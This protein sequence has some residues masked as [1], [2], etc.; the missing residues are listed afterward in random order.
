MPFLG[1]IV[2]HTFL[3][4][5][6]H[7]RIFQGLREREREREREI[8]NFFRRSLVNMS[9]NGVERDV[10]EQILTDAVIAIWL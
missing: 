5:D 9:S 3:W 7:R 8:L 10:T 1:F 6:D 4:C 2:S